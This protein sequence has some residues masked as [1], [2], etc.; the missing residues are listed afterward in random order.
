MKLTYIFTIYIV[1]TFYYIIRQVQETIKQE[2]EMIKQGNSPL[3]DSTYIIYL[4]NLFF[5]AVVSILGIVF[6]GN[7]YVPLTNYWLFILIMLVIYGV[8]EILSATLE[9]LILYPIQ[10]HEIKKYKLRLDKRADEL[11]KHMQ[12]SNE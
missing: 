3:G 11:N 5:R 12:D 10:Q 6:I 9:T 8:L 7:S 4:L 2:R 1:F